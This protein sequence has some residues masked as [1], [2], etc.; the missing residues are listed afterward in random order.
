MHMIVLVIAESPTMFPT[1]QSPNL[2]LTVDEIK[3]LMQSNQNHYKVDDSCNDGYFVDE[4]TFHYVMTENNGS[5]INKEEP[6]SKYFRFQKIP[7]VYPFGAE[8]FTVYQMEEEVR[9]CQ[10]DHQTR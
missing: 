7:R 1:K 6:H 3:I 5:E 4:D 9:N 8:L 2:F 10:A